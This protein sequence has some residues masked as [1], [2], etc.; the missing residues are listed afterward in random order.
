MADNTTLPSGTGGDTIRTLDKSGTGIPKT[1]MVAVDL[2]GG[3]GRGE[4]ILTLPMQAALADIPVD[5]DGTPLFSLSPTSMDALE[6][7]FRQTIAAVSAP[8]QA[9]ALEQQLGLT[10]NQRYPVGD[11]RRYGAVADWNGTTGTDNSTAFQNAINAAAGA[12]VIVPAGSFRINRTLTNTIVSNAIALGVFS[13]SD[14]QNGFQLIGAGTSTTFLINTVANGYMIDVQGTGASFFATGVVMTDFTISGVGVTAAA[15]SGIRLRGAYLID[16][17]RVVVTSLSGDGLTIFDAVASDTDATAYGKVSYCLFRFNSGYGVKIVTTV[18]TGVPLAYVIFENCGIDYNLTGGLYA[19]CS[20][21]IFILYCSCVHNGASGSDGGIHFGYNGVFNGPIV[22]AHCELG[23]NNKPFNIKIEAGV[24]VRILGNRVIANSTDT[25]MTGHIILGNGT[26]FVDNALIEGEDIRVDAAVTP[27]VYLTC[28]TGCT[29]IRLVRPRQ[30]LF[31]AGGQSLTN[32][33]FNTGTGNSTHLS[34]NFATGGMLTGFNTA[35]TIFAPSATRQVVAMNAPTDHYLDLQAGG[36]CVGYMY[37]VAGEWRIN[38]FNAPIT[39][40]AGNTFR[41]QIS[42]AGVFSWN[43]GALSSNLTQVVTALCAYK[44]S[45]TTAVNNTLTADATLTLTFNETGKYELEIFLAFAEVT[46]GTG[47]FSFDLSSGTATIAN[48]L[49]GVTGWSTAAVSF[50]GDTTAA[51]ANAMATISTT[52]GSP[53]WMRAKGSLSVTGVGTLAIRW[54]Q[55]TT[56]A[57]A[58]TL[59]T[60]SYI[61][62]TKVA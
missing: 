56:S 12:P 3:D 41:G 22:I 11:V 8:Y 29:D 20:Q 52:A 32:A 25:A 34:G 1:E 55:N 40:Y 53:S 43:S 42:T 61:K 6:M 23:N 44:P 27:F 26:Q 31:G 16:L 45:D 2:G 39:L 36:N 5:D 62:A 35:N 48:L 15:S 58:T 47:G 33:T 57:N 24:V 21:Q 50:V 13:A 7:L 51:T 38:G 54:A 49:L 19:E 18:S 14:Q 10:L 60:G 28:N 9:T 37:W 4:S 17:T 59:K 46:T 30:S